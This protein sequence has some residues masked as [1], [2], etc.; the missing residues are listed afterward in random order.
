MPALLEE[1]GVDTSPDPNALH[2]FFPLHGTVPA[3]RAVLQGVRKLPSATVR[4]VEP[5]G[6]HRDRCYWR[7]S[8][9]RRPEHAGPD[10]A[11]WCDA[12][13]DA[14]RTAVRRRTVGDV[15]VGVLLSGGGLD[16]TTCP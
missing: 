9:T 11:D 4:G 5:D 14:R 13:L 1:G 3:S 7:P 15:P 8:Y 16:S 10:A 2:Q 6:S 12:E